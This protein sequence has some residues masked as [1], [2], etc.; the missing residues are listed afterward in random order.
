[1]PANAVIDIVHIDIRALDR[2]AD[3]AVRAEHVGE[4]GTRLNAVLDKYTATDRE[5]PRYIQPAA[6]ACAQVVVGLVAL[7]EIFIAAGRN[8]EAER[9]HAPGRVTR[10]RYTG[11]ADGAGLFID[12]V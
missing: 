12:R 5:I 7:V 4:V 2:H 1:G 11:I 10:S 8:V 6:Q 9:V 3:R